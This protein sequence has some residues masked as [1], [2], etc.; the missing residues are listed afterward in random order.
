MLDSLKSV[1]EP[2]TGGDIKPPPYIN[3]ENSQENERLVT[4]W[5]NEVY[6]ESPWLTSSKKLNIVFVMY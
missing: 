4:E 1:D 3:G 2:Y 5:L 6:S